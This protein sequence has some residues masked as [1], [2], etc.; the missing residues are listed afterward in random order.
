M[1]SNHSKFCKDIT[2]FEYVNL[3]SVDFNQQNEIVMKQT[4]EMMK[5][6]GFL[7]LKNVPNFDEI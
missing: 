7:K 4:I 2:N 6:I 1:I 5:N 3:P